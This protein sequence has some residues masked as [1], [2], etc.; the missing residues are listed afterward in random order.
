MV[1]SISQIYKTVCTFCE[2]FGLSDPNYKEFILVQITYS[3]LTGT[4]VLHFSII[5]K[6]LVFNTNAKHN[7][8][9]T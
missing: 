8:T 2:E 7:Y 5:T 4:L 3:R 6:N 9:L 1:W